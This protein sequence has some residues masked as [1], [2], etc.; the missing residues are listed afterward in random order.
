[1]SAKG[2]EMPCGC[3][4]SLIQ[5]PLCAGRGRYPERR[6]TSRRATDSVA[7]YEL[8]RLMNE[9]YAPRLAPD[10]YEQGMGWIDAHFPE[11]SR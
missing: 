4:G 6:E 8:L 5:C 10:Q 1:M 2:N 9:V 7:R 11:V 3:G